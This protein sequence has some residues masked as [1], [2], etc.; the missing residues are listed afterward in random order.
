VVEEERYSLPEIK[1]ES[2]L[3]E[4]EIG[5]DDS[6]CPVAKYRPEFV[7]SGYIDEAKSGWFPKG[8]RNCIGCELCSPTPDTSF[9]LCVDTLVSAVG[10]REEYSPLAFGGV[11]EAIVSLQ[12]QNR[13]RQNRLGWIN[14]GIQVAGVNDKSQVGL[15]A[16]EAPYLDVLLGNEIGFTPTSEIRAAVDLLNSVGI[17][18]VVLPDEVDTGGDRLHEG[19]K[20]SFLALGMHNRD[21]FKSCGVKT[22][23]TTC[24]DCYYTLRYRYKQHIPGWDFR[25][26][27][28]A[29]YLVEF[30][31]KLT[32]LPSK[33]V[34]AIQP[35][36]RYSDPDNR[37]S[38]RKLTG[39]IPGLIVKE[40]EPGHPSTFGGWRQFDSVTKHI[41]TDFLKAAEK[42]GANILLIPSTR[43]LVRLLEGRRPGSWEETSIEIKGFYG[44]LSE[45]HTV[46]HEFAG[47]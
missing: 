45:R 5:P 36:D 42:T 40:I 15:F 31:G 24:D 35:P 19:D 11:I 37:D 38:I 25:V 14:E 16:G 6:K 27:R 10:V 41:E 1:C 28:L 8:I 4:S 2:G 39:Q 17:K 18:P 12:V 43:M 9:P 32:F 21:L 23:V 3:V 47:A 7:P 46:H 26:M 34:V 33:E 44:F 29:D 30:G 13:F 20:E 22:I